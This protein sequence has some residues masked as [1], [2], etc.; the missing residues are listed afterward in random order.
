MVIVCYDFIIKSFTKLGG[1]LR[2]EFAEQQVMKM[3][4]WKMLNVV[5]FREQYEVQAKFISKKIIAK[6]FVNLN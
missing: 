1:C 4:T 3:K 5:E 2:C 6:D